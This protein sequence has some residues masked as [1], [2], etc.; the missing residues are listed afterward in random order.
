MPA[1]LLKELSEHDL[2]LLFVKKFFNDNQ[3][4]VKCSRKLINS[5][6]GKTLAGSYLRDQNRANLDESD[7]HD[8]SDYIF[9]MTGKTAKV[10]VLGHGAYGRVKVAEKTTAVKIQRIRSN[11]QLQQ[12]QK[13]AEINLDV[14]VALT[15]L[16]VRKDLKN[17]DDSDSDSDSENEDENL[18]NYKV[19]QRMRHLGESLSKKIA[20]ERKALQEAN[21]QPSAQHNQSLQEIDRAIE[22]CLLVDKLHTGELSN[23]HTAYAHRDIKPD[24]VLIDTQGH[25]HLIDFGST[26]TKLDEDK[27]GYDLH[28]TTPAYAAIDIKNNTSIENFSF[29]GCVL[30]L[31][32]QRDAAGKPLIIT[33]ATQD[34][35]AMLRTIAHPLDDNDS[36]YHS[37]LSTTTLAQLP[38][39]LRVLLDTSM[40]L[41]HVDVA[42]RTE[43][44]HF[45]AATLILYKLKGNILTKDDI[46][47]LRQNVEQQDQLIKENIKKQAEQITTTTQ[48]EPVATLTTA[49]ESFSEY[50]QAVLYFAQHPEKTKYSRKE[51]GLP[52]SYFKE[53]DGT[54]FSIANKTS[55][56][57]AI[58][59]GAH[60]RV[61]G[62]HG[63]LEEAEKNTVVKI[64]WLT[65]V[66]ALQQARKEAAINLDLGVATGG[67]IERAFLDEKGQL[68]Y[69]VYQRMCNL[70]DKL[71]DKLAARTEPLT[72]EET[73]HQLEIDIDRSIS[74]CLLVN[75]MHTGELSSSKTP[76]AHKDIKPGNIL[77][78]SSGL[79]SLVD[80]GTTTSQLHG[81]AFAPTLDGTLYYLPLDLSVIQSHHDLTN[82]S[83][84]VSV[85]VNQL[86]EEVTNVT[87]DKIGTLRTIWLPPELQDKAHC[88]L[89]N[90]S[91]AQL[92]QPLQDLLNTQEISP[93]LTT[94]RQTENEQFFAAVLI[95]YRNNNYQITIEEIQTL[96]TD[97]Q[98]Q[99]TIIETAQKARSDTI[100]RAQAP[101]TTSNTPT[102]STT[103]Y[104]V[105]PVTPPADNHIIK[106]HEFKKTLS[107]LS[108]NQN[109]ENI[110][111]IIPGK[112]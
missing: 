20:Q 89:S 72:E 10:K 66:E 111:T 69:K 53:A 101:S 80:F 88:L 9:Q 60:G 99:A 81:S 39:Q 5:Y 40:I 107:H 54:V 65:S 104:P 85:F 17:K 48:T 4:A 59:K 62:A 27:L 86:Q 38:Q 110:T 24:N 97:V 25:L 83:K 100:A 33:N 31:K 63:G 58:G 7:L 21:D 29:L 16:I 95:T 41:P 28:H 106:Q 15:S 51:S 87:Q 32:N 18:C 42:R 68:I 57:H 96:R 75:Q 22:L 44:A 56:E 49:Q 73:R 1:K 109:Q 94:E 77:I 47:K 13:E 30:A 6:N 79:L 98:L 70:G 71:S 93:H 43:T 8:Q 74:L 36:K 90:S 82:F 105:S 35:I 92:P 12:A 26:T 84:N 34:R 91:F 64:Q 37:I 3:E 19:Y 61:K 52:E 23:S 11:E 55:P 112:K 78:D 67:L 102:T 76:Y 14:G 108:G 45:F 2:E 46:D 103:A 50:E